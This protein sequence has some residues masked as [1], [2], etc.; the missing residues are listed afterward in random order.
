MVLLPY[1][2]LRFMICAILGLATGL[3]LMTN[4]VAFR[5]LRVPARLGFLWWHVTA[6]SGAFL[7][8]QA[9]VVDRVIRH[10]QTEPTWQTYV[11]L[12]GSALFLT[13]QVI[14]FNVER[15]RLSHYR[16]MTDPDQPHVW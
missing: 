14:I 10:L 8:F 1:D 15:N 16:A 9:V 11:T 6:I 2:G 3:M 12:L 7:C 4:V 13:A 5:V